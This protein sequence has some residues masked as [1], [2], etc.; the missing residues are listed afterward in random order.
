GGWFAA[1]G[2]KRE[3]VLGDILEQRTAYT[4]GGPAL[5]GLALICDGRFIPLDQLGSA[6]LIAEV[7]RWENLPA[8]AAGCFIIRA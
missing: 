7:L 1:P 4:D 6:D 2:A 3:Q 8:N 5:P